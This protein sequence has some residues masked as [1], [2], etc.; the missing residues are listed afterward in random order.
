MDSPQLNGHAFGSS[1]LCKIPT[2]EACHNCK[3][4]IIEK[5]CDMYFFGSGTSRGM[6]FSSEYDQLFCKRTLNQQRTY[7]SNWCGEWRE[8]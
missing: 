3:F 6:R 8:R 5:T 1:E 2:G 4:G 7:D